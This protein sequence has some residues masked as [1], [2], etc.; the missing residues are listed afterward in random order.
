VI[1]LSSTKEQLNNHT[2]SWGLEE[3]D[4]LLG[5]LR[6][7]TVLLIEGEP[8]TGKTSLA[9]TLIANNAEKAG[10]KGTY[11]TIGETSNKLIYQAES[12]N[13][14]LK[15]LSDEGLVKI[16]E[17]PILSDPR[18]ID[19]I[20]ATIAE[21]SEASE[22]VVV[23]SISPLLKVLKD[24]I[25]KRAWIQT[26]LYSFTSVRDF[27]L[28]LVADK[29]LVNDEDLKILEFIADAV[30]EL[31]KSQETTGALER[32]INVKKFRGREVM[33]TSI[34]FEITRNGI[35]ILNYLSRRTLEKLKPDRR[36]YRISCTPL[37][38][39]LPESLQPGMSV[40]L[41]NRTGRDFTYTNLMLALAQEIYGLLKEGRKLSVITFNPE[42]STIFEEVKKRA[43]ENVIVTYLNPLAIDP[44]KVTRVELEHV[45]EK[46]VE[47]M[48]IF[49]PERIFHAYPSNPI[50]LYR[51][52]MY[53][54]NNLKAAGVS[55]LR[56]LE[57]SRD[58]KIPSV[59][60]DWSDIVLEL[61]ELPD[62]EIVLRP[63]KSRAPPKIR[64]VSDSEFSKCI[65]DANLVARSR[66]YVSPSERGIHE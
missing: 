2:I 18:I 60:L 25:S 10:G 4:E 53:A 32:F 55:S 42:I 63:V 59:Y 21:S 22:L 3:L 38:K 39:I 5:M 34:P 50:I 61:Y 44:P 1:R 45:T 49:N 7:G 66:K 54:V 33:V 11:V 41:I 36:A 14:H 57:L 37:H 40:V 9:L 56:Y 48:L 51:Y 64:V 24:Y 46:G 43:R 47:F 29:I 8:G 16:K 15:R 31:A 12:M 13:I 65:K 23:D 62:G 52:G 26:S 30:V 27:T 28:V 35:M 6:P 17:F 58:E 19:Q 20:T